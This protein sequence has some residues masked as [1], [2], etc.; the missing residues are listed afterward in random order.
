MKKNLT[1]YSW[2]RINSGLWF[3]RQKQKWDGYQKLV[4]TGFDVPFSR[5]VDKIA[6]TFF[7]LLL[8]LYIN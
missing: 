8:F 4:W 1:I 3:G 7:S 5:M 2:K 6:K